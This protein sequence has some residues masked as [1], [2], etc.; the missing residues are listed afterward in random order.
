[1]SNNRIVHQVTKEYMKK[2]RRRTITTLLGIVFMVMLMTCVFVGKDTAVSYLEEV[3]SLEK[4]SWH[5]NVYDVTFEE[6]EKI[7]ISLSEAHATERSAY[8]KGKG[9]FILSIYEKLK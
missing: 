2:N 5:L 8:T 6:Y 9:A 7:K 4:G 1:M 3:A